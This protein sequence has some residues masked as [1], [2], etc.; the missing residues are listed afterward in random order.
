[1]KC[2]YCNSK[3]PGS[4]CKWCDEHFDEEEKVTPSRMKIVITKTYDG[5]E[6]T[7]KQ[8]YDRLKKSCERVRVQEIDIVKNQCEA[9]QMTMGEH[10]VY[11]Q[12]IKHKKGDIRLF[13][14]NKQQSKV[15]VKNI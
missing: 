6:Y 2:L 7:A 14:F 8:L 5:Y 11:E 10:L 9:H 1:M 15:A 4:Y 12:Y 3:L 13:V